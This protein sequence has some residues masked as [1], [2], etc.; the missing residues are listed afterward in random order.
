VAQRK[1]LYKAS[2]NTVPLN[3]IIY[4]TPGQ[5][6]RGGDSIA[7]THLQLGGLEAG[8]QHQTLPALPREKTQYPLYMYG[9]LGSPQGWSGQH[10]ISCPHQNSILRLSSLYQVAIL[11]MLSL[12]PRPI[13]L[14]QTS[15]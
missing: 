10:G 7:T 2:P 9:R 5:A 11:T 13:K 15:R 6:Q 1:I 8:V 12:P 14:P 3:V 4:D